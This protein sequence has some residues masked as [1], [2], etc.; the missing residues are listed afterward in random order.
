MK[1]TTQ[2][3]EELFGVTRQ[4]II[5]EWVNKHNM[6]VLEHGGL[7]A[8]N[9]YIFDL[10]SVIDWHIKRKV[11]SLTFDENT[12]KPLDLLNYEKYRI[13]RFEREQ[14]EKTLINKND[15]IVAFFTVLKNFR[16]ALYQLPTMLVED[17][18]MDIDPI[19]IQNILDQELQKIYDNIGNLT[20]ES[21][22]VDKGDI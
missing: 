11:D 19:E 15:F 4:T 6:P 20:T 16:E 18:E 12:A 5:G 1:V 9:K 14:L 21:S 17:F 7:G 22:G 8:G 2:D 3:L 13:A 10:K